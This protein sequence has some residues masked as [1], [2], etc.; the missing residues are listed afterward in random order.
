M[1]TLLQIN[2]LGG[3]IDK[4]ALEPTAAYPHRKFGFLGELQ[5]YYDRPEREKTAVAV[6]RE[7]Q[8]LFR[9]SGVTAHYANYPDAD[10][11]NW[12][13]AYYGASYPRLQKLKKA[14][15]PDDRIRHP[16]SVRLG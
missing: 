2:T 1:P 16:Q 5:T 14:L 12:Q 11:P 9:K 7:I 3:A 15:D 8:S 4:P 13:S 6:V 10:L